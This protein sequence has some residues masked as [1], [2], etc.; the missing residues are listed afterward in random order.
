MRLRLVLGP[1]TRASHIPCVKC[2]RRAWQGGIAEYHCFLKRFTSFKKPRGYFL[3]KAAGL[4][5]TASLFNYD[6]KKQDLAKKTPAPTRMKDLL[7]LKAG[8]VS[9]YCPLRIILNH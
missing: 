6:K 9:P 5:H 7:A 8:V 4:V 1:A 3:W 2:P